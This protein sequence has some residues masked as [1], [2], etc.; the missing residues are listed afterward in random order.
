MYLVTK[1]YRVVGMAYQEINLNN[2]N[3]NMDLTKG[4]NKVKNCRM[5]NADL[6][7]LDYD[8]MFDVYDI[9]TDKL[10][11]EVSLP[12]L[13]G[14]HTERIFNLLVV[15]QFNMKL[16]KSGI[17]FWKFLDVTDG[18][19]RVPK[20][21]YRVEEWN[22]L[23]GQSPVIQSNDSLIVQDMMFFFKVRFEYI[24]ENSIYWKTVDYKRNAVRY[25]NILDFYNSIITPKIDYFSQK[26][27]KNLYVKYDNGYFNF[28]I[29]A[30][31]LRYLTKLKVIKG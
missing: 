25:M 18:V 24:D 1:F 30:S 27:I 7:T 15:D 9:N 16:I 20:S 8:Y 22:S 6:R 11:K 26:G 28:D 3:I 13:V 2:I 31:T 4:K 29:G 5:Y 10:Y 17:D 23:H 12:E 19:T 14:K 21:D